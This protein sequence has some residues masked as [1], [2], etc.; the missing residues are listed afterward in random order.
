MSHFGNPAE[1]RDK[2]N[3]AILLS[4]RGDKKGK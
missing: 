1:R 3:E 2:D 4:E